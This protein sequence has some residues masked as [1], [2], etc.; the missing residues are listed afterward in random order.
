MGGK[1]QPKGEICIW[2]KA[3]FE[4]YGILFLSGTLFDL[5]W[6]PYVHEI[7]WNP[8]I[9]FP[10]ISTQVLVPQTWS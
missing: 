6:G 5:V 3:F 8:Q 9:M 1:P 4:K 7:T 2:K 10:Y